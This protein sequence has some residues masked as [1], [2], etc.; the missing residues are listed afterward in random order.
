MNQADFEIGLITKPQGIKGE[1]RVLPTTHD[2]SRFELLIG[3][4]VK[5]DGT[6][7]SLTSARLQRG[8]VIVKFAEVSD[9]NGAEALIRKKIHIPAEKALPLGADEY[10]VRDLEGLSVETESGEL[11]GTVVKVLHTAANDVYV[12]ELEDGKPFMIPAIK[13]VIR[14][15]DINK[16]K[17]TVRLFD[18]L[19]ELFA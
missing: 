8:I 18:G 3:Q 12:V 14:E 1:L 16:G 15:V 11:L 19:K 10:Y 13:D 17:M 5:V 7:L 4:S 6:T 2:P 9:R